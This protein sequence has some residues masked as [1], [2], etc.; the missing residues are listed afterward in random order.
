[1]SSPTAVYK[2]YYYHFDGLGSIIAVTDSTGNAVEA[3][4]YS[5]YGLADNPTTA[6]NPYLF[7]GRQFD[8]ETGLY[9]YR[10]R[11]YSAAIDYLWRHSYVTFV[12]VHTMVAVCS[13][14]VTSVE[15]L[16]TLKK[17]I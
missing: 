9:Y 8:V 15:S 7:T 13:Q 5:V 17:R 10:A 6:G 2:A 11:Y 4:R 3:Y 1:V 12:C 16:L 14:Y